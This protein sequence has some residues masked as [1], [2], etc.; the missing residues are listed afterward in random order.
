MAGSCSVIV[1][2]EAPL[3]EIDPV[4]LYRILALRAEIFV[5]EQAC[6]Y[7]DPDGRDVEPATVQLWLQ[8]GERV[9]ATL[10]LMWDAENVAHIGRVAT[11]ADA[12]GRGL[13]E[14]LVR[15]ALELAGPVDVV[16]G[17]QTY[18]KGWYAQFGFVRDGAD[19]LEDGIPHLPMRLHRIQSEA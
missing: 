15:R 3:A 16:L 4:T 9:L 14:R 5:V 13:A 10:R 1:L 6:A 12:R 18:L 17:A 11:A 8:D 19:Y 7:L 2:R